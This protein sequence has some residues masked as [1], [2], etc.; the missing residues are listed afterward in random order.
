M[1]PEKEKPD[2][3]EKKRREK[4]RQEQLFIDQLRKAR[5][6]IAETD[7]EESKHFND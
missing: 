4:R 5:Q 2:K 1:S 7:F 3:E 6:L